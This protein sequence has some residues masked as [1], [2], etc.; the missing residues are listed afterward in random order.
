MSKAETTNTPR[1]R[2]LASAAVA[3]AAAATL[4]AGAALAS[5][6]ADPI[7]AAIEAHHQGWKATNKIFD[8][9]RRL[10]ETL[11][12]ELRRTSLSRWEAKIVETDSPEWIANQRAICATMDAEAESE[13]V[14]ATIVPT[15]MAGVSALLA[16]AISDRD[17]LWRELEDDD[18]IARPWEFFVMCNCAEALESLA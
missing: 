14:L 11:P 5:G 2:F 15:T 13:L 16:L 8:E 3:G 17:C 12:K 9:Q 6:E 18:G 4:S 7:F 1:R 10:E